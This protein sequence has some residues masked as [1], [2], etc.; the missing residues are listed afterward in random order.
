MAQHD[1]AANPKAD[2]KQRLGRSG[3]YVDH[4]ARTVADQTDAD[5]RMDLRNLC[6]VAF[7]IRH[8]TE[9]H[10]S[11]DHSAGE[12]LWEGKM[13]AADTHDSSKNSGQHTHSEEVQNGTLSSAS[14]NVLSAAWKRLKLSTVQD[15]S[16]QLSNWKNVTH[17][18]FRTPPLGLTVDGGK[19]STTMKPQQSHPPN[20]PAVQS[21]RMS[22]SQNEQWRSGFGR[23]MVAL[24]AA[25]NRV[26]S[27]LEIQLWASA[28][29][30]HDLVDL[31]E[32]F[33]DF[34]KTSEGF[35]TPGKVEMFVRKC[36]R[37]RLGIV[38][39]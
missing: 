30:D 13:M 14:K 10:S 32:G 9:R 35:P 22:N 34:L 39:R 27:L 11:S 37:N 4:V 15:D 3:N 5:R 19:Q 36:R 12:S 28:L 17:D 38:V 1:G 25:H 29:S 18:T 8:D 16:P 20:L 21:R 33:S 23:L 26:Y 31:N 7:A 6:V 24:S 2:S